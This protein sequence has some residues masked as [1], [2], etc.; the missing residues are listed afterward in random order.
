M[1]VLEARHHYKK[2]H[3][4][5]SDEKNEIGLTTGNITNVVSEEKLREIQKATLDQTKD[6]LSK[7]FG[8][9]GSNTKIITGYEQKTITSAYSKDGLKV[10]KNII[11]GGVI[12]ASII[13]ELITITSH[14]EHEVG[15]GTTSTVI[16]S[17]L[18]FSNLIELQKKHSVPPY[19]LI[20]RFKM[21]VNTIKKEILDNGKECTLEDI[22][23]ISMISTNHNEEVSTNIKNIYEEYGMNVDL[24]V[25]ISNNTDSVIREYDGLT[26][27]EG[28]GDPAYVNAPDNKAVIN[29]ANVYH[30]V[31]PIDD[32]YMISIFESIIKHNIY[33][34]VENDEQPIPTVITCPRISKDMSA[35]LKVLCDLLYRFDKQN[36]K[37]AKPP[38]LIVTD[39]VA[40]DEIIMEDI[41]DI[42]GCKPIRKYIDPKNLAKDQESGLAPTVE[43]AYT[44]AGHAEEV[45]ADAKHTK[46]INPQYMRTV[47]EN[48]EVVDNP[49]YAGKIAFLEAE[50]EAIKASANPS[51]IGLFGKRLAALKANS[52]EYLVGG[53]TVADRD[54]TKDLVEDAI[55]NCKSASLYGIG[56]AANF[57]GL[58]GVARVMDMDSECD[59]DG[60][61]ADCIFN[62]Y[63]EISEI[64]YSTVCCDKEKVEKY[65]AKSIEL[66]APY[67]IS[68]GLLPDDDNNVSDNVKC[69]IMLDINILDTI[70]KIITLMVTSNQCLLQA[71]NLNKY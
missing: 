58:R 31:D 18:I 44:F 63:F 62:A 9:M 17:A 49:V 59:L 8:P 52:V 46:F 57:E 11:N 10:L 36:M 24:S 41:S 7:T 47:D 68:S 35:V 42:C 3:E 34:R 15:D 33:D 16:L 45:V 71:S 67:D 65:V 28:Y 51:E 27:T 25:G 38:V 14:V 53:V 50:I 20:R 13:E 54:A 30:F 23:N 56:N 61:I 69:S 22:Y 21:I 66:G 43:N 64:L 39:V 55:K 60:D 19:E 5:V 48:G 2:S 29:D 40:S 70:S 37:S 26:I 32:G 1:N 4:K 6:F 12:E